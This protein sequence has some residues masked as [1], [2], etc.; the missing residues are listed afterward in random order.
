MRASRSDPGA[1]D[2]LFRRHAARIDLWVR[3]RVTDS[4]TAADLVA[5]T[6]AQAL[7]SATSFRGKR[8]G[9]ATAWLNGI[10]R[11][12]VLQYYRRNRVATRARAK[13]AMLNEEAVPDVSDAVEAAIDARA[14]ANRLA[15]AILM[16][17]QD[18]RLALQLRVLDRRSYDDVAH[19]LGCT[20]TAARMK[21]SRGLRSLDAAIKGAEG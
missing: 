10:A 19:L 15:A 4:E 20:K 14:D 12:L 16:L 1:F 2:E 17:P 21:V 7:V 13:L 3:A 8:T 11:N 9:S 5:E 6:F 18:Q